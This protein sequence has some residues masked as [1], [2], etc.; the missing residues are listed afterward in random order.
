[1]Y[2]QAIAAVRN[3][4]K[5]TQSPPAPAKVQLPMATSSKPGK[6]PGYQT[7]EEEKAALRRYED[8]KRA[9]DRVQGPSEYPSGAPGGSGPEPISYDS[10][11]PAASSGSAAQSM[12]PPP[13]NE[14]PPPFEAGPPLT[15]PQQLS[16]KERLR[17]AYEAQ[18]AASL[19]RQT[20]ATAMIPRQASPAVPPASYDTSPPPFSGPAYSSATA[21]K[22]L[23]RRRFEAQD[24]AV[25]TPSPTPPQ[26][27]PARNG[28]VP[29]ARSGSLVSTAPSL[30]SRPAPLP[31]ISD[32]SGQRVLSAAEEKALLR[33]KYEGYDSASS[34][35][36]PPPMYLNGYVSALGSASS[37]GAPPSIN[38][39]LSYSSSPRH[40]SPP[41]L[42]PR[43]PQEY[44]KETQEE[45]ARV[46]RMT[47]N[48]AMPRIAEDF[49][50]SRKP[51]AIAAA[52]NEWSL[53]NLPPLPSKRD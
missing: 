12:A 24:A 9:V 51:S 18:D 5:Q 10:L 7:A 35:E 20:T 1:M 31:P 25:T 19:S 53:G 22:E 39:G 14:L 26:T 2:S 3:D 16:E 23:L 30:R 49:S 46:V 21:E 37:S 4:S 6:V 34:G 11:Y 29:P 52:P 40:A 45:D 50:M 38:S 27:P 13:L 43:P 42:M 32:G 8:A 36:A 44:I 17:R 15:A 28:S 48:G 41:P 33:A 47:M